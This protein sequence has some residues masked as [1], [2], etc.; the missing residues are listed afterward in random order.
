M[1]EESFEVQSKVRIEDPDEIIEALDKEAI[2]I[3]YT[4][5]Y[6]EF[7]TYFSFEKKKEGRLRYREDEFINKKGKMNSSIKKEKSPMFAED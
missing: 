6:H 4:R 2:E 7:D 1:Q 3:I 5:H